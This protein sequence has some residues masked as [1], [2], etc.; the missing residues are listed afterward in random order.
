M[1]AAKKKK[2]KKS[3]QLPVRGVN[4]VLKKIYEDLKNPAGF[5]SPYF[6][7]KS[8]KKINPRIKMSHVVSWLNAQKAY[9]KH[10]AIKTKFV[11]RPVLTRGLQYQYQAD[12]V[13]Y[14]AISRDN[15]GFRYVLTIIDCFS[16]FALAIP[17]KRKTGENVAQAFRKAFESMP[18][19]EKLQT[20]D[21]T[22]FYNKNVKEV[23]NENNV[24]HFSTDQE[25]KASIVERFNRTL[26]EK[27]QKYMVA[28]NTLRYIDILP[29]FLYGYNNKPHGSLDGLSPVE[30]TKKNEKAVHKNMYGEYLSQKKKRHKFSINDTVRI[31]E[32]RKTFHKSYHQNFTDK[33]FI[34]VD[35][36]N[37]HPPTYRVKD[38]ENSDLIRGAFYEEQLQKVDV[39]EK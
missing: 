1:V 20:D 24:H 31:A 21:G 27:I 7:Y 36:L 34:I 28:K 14:Q 10:R 35:K 17:I 2:K 38:S 26:R 16:R 18:P 32:Y 30:V 5:S 9:T 22:E 6:L 25:L 11:R 37:T 19:P 4:V 39:E 8:A 23:L 13:D 12:L 33:I 3:Y 15:A 29:D